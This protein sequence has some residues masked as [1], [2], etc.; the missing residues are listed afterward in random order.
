M[1]HSLL[2][3]FTREEIPNTPPPHKKK[4]TLPFEAIL[5]VP[6]VLKAMTGI[7]SFITCIH[8][9]ITAHSIVAFYI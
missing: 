9:L 6:L 5:G 7:K 1:H 2:Y 4:L 8:N 3:F